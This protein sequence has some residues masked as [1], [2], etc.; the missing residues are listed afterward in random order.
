MDTRLRESGNK[1]KYQVSGIIFC[2]LTLIITIITHYTLH[3]TQCMAQEIKQ[4]AVAGLFYPK[5]P[6]VL[7]SKIEQF[8][9][10]IDTPKI[11]GDIK[12]LIAPHAGYEYSGK[13]AAAGFKAIKDK[14]FKT[15]IILGPSHRMDFNGASIYPEG[16][17]MTPLG[18]VKIDPLAKALINNKITFNPQ[19]FE[20]EHSIEVQIP[21]LQKVLKDFQIIPILIG[22]STDFNSCKEIAERIS[23]FIK[24]RNDVLIVV[25]TDMYH[26]DNY[27]E[28]VKTDK[29][30]LEQ[31]ERFQPQ[32]LYNGAILADY[33]L[34]GLRGAVI[35]QIVAKDLGAQSAK[36]LAHSNSTDITGGKYCV[37][38]S[39]IIFY[40]D[41]GG[42]SML[43][44]E[45]RKSLLEMARSTIEEYVKTKKVKEFEI[46]DP[47]FLKE[48]GVFVTIHKDGQLRGCIGNIIAHEPLYLSVRNM[49]IASATEDPRFPPLTKDELGKIDVEIS[50][51]SEPK[52]IYNIDE[53][54]LGTH[55]VIVKKGF[56]SGVFLPQV[57]TETGWNREEF[58]SYLC[59]HKAGLDPL[60]W[61]D[62]DTQLF[63]FTA[64][65][66][67]EK[68]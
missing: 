43:T 53:I 56:Q 51:L 33:Q 27:R 25:S 31:I 26:G 63:T 44:K 3:I 55:G 17:F 4:P 5:Q 29:A 10:S 67:S 45:Q 57:A 42:D 54:K 8:L 23:S 15:V 38:Y 58:V 68:D 16:A 52:R 14:P 62:K 40:R 61:K 36:V 24:D 65:V 12:V 13:I 60:A 46:S 6:E 39:S 35:A 66:F 37:G 28:A 48:R 18:A 32:D 19:P 20:G 34:C 21:F 30:T 11:D 47:V 22:Y 1:F 7:S 50:V 59:S 49:A 41:R 9:S 2:F 64:D